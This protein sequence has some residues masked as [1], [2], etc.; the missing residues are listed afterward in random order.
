MIDVLYIYIRNAPLFPKN[1][2]YTRAGARMRENRARYMFQKWGIA[3]FH[4]ENFNGVGGLGLPH[5][6]GAAL[7]VSRRIVQRC[8]W[9][10]SA[11]PK[12]GS[13]GAALRARAGARIIGA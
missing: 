11:P 13:G 8:R 4:G 7:Y 3:M 10:R 1:H 9:V 12:W 6:G 2:P 5:P